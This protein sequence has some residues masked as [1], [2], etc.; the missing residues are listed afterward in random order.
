MGTYSAD[1]EKISRLR[2]KNRIAAQD[3]IPAQGIRTDAAD[4]VLSQYDKQA[5]G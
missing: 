2:M 4:S 1:K 3:L 5:T